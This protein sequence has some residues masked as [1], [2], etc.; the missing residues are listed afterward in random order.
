MVQ[1]QE[2]VITHVLGGIRRGLLKE[3]MFRL[4]FEGFHIVVEKI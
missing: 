3:V 1:A 4:D 2:R